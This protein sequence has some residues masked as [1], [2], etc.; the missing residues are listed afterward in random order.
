MSPCNYDEYHP[1]WKHIRRQILDQ[2]D[3]CCEFC[4]VANG[5]R[6]FRTGGE[7]VEAGLAVCADPHFPHRCIVI[8]LT[9]AHLDHDVT[10]NDPTN[11][12]ALCQR[13]HLRWDIDHHTRNAAETRRTK[14]IHSGQMELGVAS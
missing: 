2:A 12:R 5:A 3:N 6:G 4:G 11:L 13:C 10:N 8:V 9:I 1:D 14:R 7:F